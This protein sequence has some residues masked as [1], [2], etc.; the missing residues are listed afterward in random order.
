ME[1]IWSVVPR[2]LAGCFAHK[3]LIAVLFSKQHVRLVK[4]D[5]IRNFDPYCWIFAAAVRASVGGRKLDIRLTGRG[6]TVANNLGL[7]FTSHRICENSDFAGGEV[8]FNQG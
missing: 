5:P 1:P 7:A 4:N 3:A 8:L 6:G 2:V